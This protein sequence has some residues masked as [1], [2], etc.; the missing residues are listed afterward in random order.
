[1]H[2]TTGQVHWHEP[3]GYKR[4]GYG[5]FDRPKTPYDL[6]MESEGIPIYRDIG[7][8][9]V[10]DLPLLPWKRTGGRE[11]G[12]MFHQGANRKPYNPDFAGWAKAAGANSPAR[13]TMER[14]GFMML[15]PVND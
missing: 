15:A 6:F 1:M 2:D 4:A 7:V 3:A 8:R 12:T 14:I 10:Q 11:H 5:K 9:K 13:T